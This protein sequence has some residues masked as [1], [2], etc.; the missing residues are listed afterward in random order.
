[1][2]AAAPGGG[3]RPARGPCGH[4]PRI[5]R[6]HQGHGLGEGRGAGRGEGPD[7]RQNLDLFGRLHHLGARRAGRRADELLERFGLAATGRKAVRQY[8]GGMRRRLDLAASLI[9]DPQVLFLDEPTTGLDPRG[10]AEVWG[11]VR[12]L[13]GGGTTV[14]LLRLAMLWIGIRLGM[15]AGRPERVQAVQ[16]LVWPVGFLS[17]AFAAPQSMPGWLGAVVEWNPLSATATAVRDLF[18]NPAAAAPSWA[19]DHAALPAVAWPLLLLAVFF[20]LAVGR[21]RGLSR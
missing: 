3:V 20:P 13:V 18:G 21:Y 16:I 10:R 9:T 2:D 7:G 14:L 11:A 1:M 19:A 5:H 17:N 15:V 6:R 4:R 12:S 8:S